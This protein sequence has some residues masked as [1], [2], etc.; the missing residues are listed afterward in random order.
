METWLVLVQFA[1][2]SPLSRTRGGHVVGSLSAPLP[3]KS[4]EPDGAYDTLE[5]SSP[6]WSPPSSSDCCEDEVPSASTA[7]SMPL[8]WPVVVMGSVEV[9]KRDVEDS[10]VEMLDKL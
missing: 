2:T 4:S 3:L 6:L 10:V 9:S 8:P 1:E 7:S 5:L